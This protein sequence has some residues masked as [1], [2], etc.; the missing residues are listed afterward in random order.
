M[1][2]QLL[3]NMS[4]RLICLTILISIGLSSCPDAV[5]ADRY[6]GKLPEDGQF[7]FYVEQIPNNVTVYWDYDFNGR[8][9]TVFACPLTGYGKVSSC[10]VPLVA[11]D[12]NYI[13]TTCPSSNPVYYLTTRECWE[14]VSCRAWFRKKGIDHTVPTHKLAVVYC[15]D[16]Y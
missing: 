15:K 2:N 5:L 6:I 7:K 10:H 14:C 11:G 1:L 16:D 12:N 4:V 9:D 8:P 13:F 3:E